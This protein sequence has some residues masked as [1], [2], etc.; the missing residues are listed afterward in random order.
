MANYVQIKSITL[1]MNQKDFIIVILVLVVIILLIV[2]CSLGTAAGTLVQPVH[3]SMKNRNSY[4][5]YEFIGDLKEPNRSPNPDEY[6]PN[7]CLLFLDLHHRLYRKEESVPETMEHI[8]EFKKSNFLRFRVW[9]SKS[10]KQYYIVFGGV[11]PKSGD[12]LRCTYYNLVAPY[13]DD[14]EA[15]LHQGFYQ[16]FEFDYKRV[17]DDFVSSSPTLLEKGMTIYLIGQSLGSMQAQ[18]A[19]VYL[20]QLGAKDIRL[21]TFSSSRLGNRAMAKRVNESCTESFTFLNTEDLFCNLPLAVMP[22]YRNQKMGLSYYHAGNQ[23]VWLTMNEESMCANHSSKT[24][25]K[26]FRQQ[27]NPVEPA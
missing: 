9:K 6:D 7:D 21:F 16:M 27:Q 26:L 5:E 18:L 15:K 1:K 3:R 12:D 17:L 23:I 10:L 13:A 20:K 11:A 4:W 2:V 25:I 8:G 14:P 19:A 24:Y 22:Y